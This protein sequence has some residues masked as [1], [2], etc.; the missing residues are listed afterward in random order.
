MT[1]KVII[2]IKEP[3]SVTFLEFVKDLLECCHYWGGPEK[4]FVSDIEII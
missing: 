3:D 4:L 2:Y 1:K